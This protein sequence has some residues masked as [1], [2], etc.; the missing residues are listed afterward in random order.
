MKEGL[1]H[2]ERHEGRGIG[3]GEGRKGRVQEG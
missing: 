2:C 1:Y 3:R